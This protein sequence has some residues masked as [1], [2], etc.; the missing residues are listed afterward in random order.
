M[1]SAPTTE[2]TGDDESGD[3]GAAPAPTEEPEEQV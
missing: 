2:P 1:P 3:G